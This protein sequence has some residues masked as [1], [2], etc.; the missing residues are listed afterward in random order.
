MRRWSIGDLIGTLLFAL[1]AGVRLRQVAE[2]EWAAGVLAAQAGLAAFLLLAR[3][4]A[5]HACPAHHQWLAWLS[6]LGP[7]A[8]RIEGVTPWWTGLAAAG[9]AVSLWGL[10]SLGRSFGIAPAD[11]GLVTRGAYRWVR[12]PMYAGELASYAALAIG[13]PSLWNGLALLLILAMLIARIRWEE[14]LID[15]YDQY[16]TQVRWRLLPKVW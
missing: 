7:F 9:V 13:S 1:L 12:H 10:V 5:R 4:S 16:R 14:S 2:G 15:G 11:R 8:L 3:R 6:V